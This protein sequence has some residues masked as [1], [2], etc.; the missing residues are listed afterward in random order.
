MKLTKLFVCFNQFIFIIK[1]QIN[2]QNTK[3]KQNYG[4]FSDDNSKF[5][6]Y[7]TKYKTFKYIYYFLNLFT[8]FSNYG[9]VF[10]PLPN[11]VVFLF[12]FYVKMTKF[13]FKIDLFDKNN[14][15]FE[16]KYKKP[17]KL[18]NGAIVNWVNSNSKAGMK[19][20]RYSVSTFN[21]ELE[22]KQ[23]FS[24]QE[25]KLIEEGIINIECLK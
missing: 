19:S 12:L 18:V 16:S 13:L 25:V 2:L 6:L 20:I 9:V 14:K 8:N 15:F 23:L 21:A 22:R 10:R 4:V 7:Y 17:G 1:A 5:D 3:N 11:E 24:N